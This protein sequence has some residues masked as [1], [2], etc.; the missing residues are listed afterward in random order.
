MSANASRLKEASECERKAEECM[1]TSMIKLKF[2]PDY[3][4]AAY[5]LER[6]A[7]CYRN[8]QEPRKAA[9]SL[10]KA[11]QYYQENRNLFHAAKAREGAAML[12]RDIKEFAEAVKLFEKAIDG[13]AESGN[14][15]TAAL[16][17]E[18]AADVLKND[19]P[20]K[21]LAIYQ[22]G[23]AL[24]Q[25]SDRAKMASQFLKQITKLSLQLEDYKGA[26]VS[27]REE[28]EKF[29]EI[30]EYPR[31]GQLGI[32]LVIVNLA[33]EDS[34]AALKDYSWVVSLSPDMQISEDGRVCENLI[35]YYDAGDDESFQ[36]VLKCGVLRS[37]DNEYLRVMKNL[38]APGGNGGIAEDDDEEGLC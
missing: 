14:L 37:M 1:K 18:K 17:V 13:Y 33:M 22:R 10:L 9:D 19:D 3:D 21:A 6:A 25:Q 26:L 15:D 23:L 7:V 36:N 29:V 20:K 30:R 28:I 32:G 11:A 4:G 27:I 5:S 8:A 34:V 16:T 38:K 35:G 31:I 24:V 2:K 12:L